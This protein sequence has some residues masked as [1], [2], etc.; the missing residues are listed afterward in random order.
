MQPLSVRVRYAEGRSSPACYFLPHPVSLAL[1][2]PISVDPGSAV[3]KTLRGQRPLLLG[4]AAK[5]IDVHLGTCLFLGYYQR[6]CHLLGCVSLSLVL[7]HCPG[8][9]PLFY[10]GRGR[11]ERVWVKWLLRFAQ[12][13]AKYWM[14]VTLYSQVQITNSESIGA[15]RLCSLFC[16]H[17]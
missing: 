5:H 6:F 14:N 16:L 10:S 13:E 17:S 4:A 2:E 8:S 7:L 12:E 1:L 9:F 11:R 3:L 15:N